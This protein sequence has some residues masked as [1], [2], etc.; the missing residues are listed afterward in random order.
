MPT[1]QGEVENGQVLVTAHIEH[2]NRREEYMALLD[3]GAQGTLVSP[4]VVDQLGLKATGYLSMTP[5]SGEPIT[6]PKYR[7][8]VTIPAGRGA[9][10]FPPG[11]ELEVGQLPFQPDNFDV[12]L[13]MDF[14]GDFH[15]T[16]Y[17]HTFILSN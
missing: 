9:S 7:A 5:A 10:V 12:L 6:T 2:E 11:G 3:T 13:G 14:L 15:F 8:T 16:M 17:G 4:R 1:I